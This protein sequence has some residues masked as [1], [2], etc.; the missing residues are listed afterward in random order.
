VSAVPNKRGQIIYGTQVSS[1][2]RK[3]G[4]SGKGQQADT[5]R[6]RRRLRWLGVDPPYYTLDARRAQRVPAIRCNRRYAS[7]SFFFD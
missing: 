5:S 7:S 2:Q 3:H 4:S 6:G 1:R